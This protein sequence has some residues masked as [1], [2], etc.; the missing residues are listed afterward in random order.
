M[1]L[2]FTSTSLA[3]RPLRAAGALG[4]IA[5]FVFASFAPAL[6]KL[7]VPTG[8]VI[9]AR[10]SSSDINTKNAQAGQAFTMHIVP[11]YPGGHSSLANARIDGHI[12]AVRSAGQGRKALLTL[13]FDRIVLPN[14]ESAPL[15]GKITSVASKSESTTARK[16]LGAGVGAAVG[17]QTIG[18]LLGGTLGSVVGLA[19]GAAGGYLYANNNKANFNVA[20]G[21]AA[22]ITTTSPM[23]LRQAR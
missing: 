18:R 15:S 6:A 9:H 14:G 19:G 11:P 17:S 23:E 3:R 21:A 7:Y 13:G 10:L 2:Q 20:Q 8:S 4:A 5:A 16:A 22:T 1:S 12:V